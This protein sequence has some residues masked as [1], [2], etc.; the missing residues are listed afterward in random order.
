MNQHKNHARVDTRYLRTT[1]VSIL[2][3]SAEVK[4]E[5]LWTTN[6]VGFRGTK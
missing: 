4:A 3:S 2:N 5:R 1:P 6:L